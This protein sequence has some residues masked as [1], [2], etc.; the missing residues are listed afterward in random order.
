MRIVGGSLRG[1]RLAEVETGGIRPTADR[2]REGLFNI[3]AHNAE[4]E[5]PDGPAPEGLDVLDVFAGTGAL[6]LEAL[7]RGA[8][9]VAFMENDPAARKIL[10]A[11]IRHAGAG[12]AARVLN[13]DAT[14][15]GAARGD[16][17]LVL[18]DPPYRQELAAVALAALER[19]GW[20][21]ADA[22]IVVETDRKEAFEIPAGFSPVDQRTYGRARLHFLRRG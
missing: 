5:G 15:P 17:G 1:L 8:A 12:H 20:L 22:L 4:F 6:G 13:A 19:N 16:F 7:S 21:T 9:S 10:D 2:T 18:M 11:N 3:L 14:K